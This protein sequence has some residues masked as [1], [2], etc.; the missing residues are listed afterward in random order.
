M[1]QSQQS[2][3]TMTTITKTTKAKGQ[4]RHLNRTCLCCKHWICIAGDSG[5]CAVNTW[6]HSGDA[7]MTC[8]WDE[9]PKWAAE[10]RL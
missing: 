9:C 8:T 7:W 10:V 6:R 5:L 3:Q 4:R 1:K 2:Q